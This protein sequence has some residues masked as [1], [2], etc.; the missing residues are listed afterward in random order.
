MFGK[1]FG[2]VSLSMAWVFGVS[3][4]SAIPFVVVSMISENLGYNFKTSL[5][6]GIAAGAVAVY[7]V[8]INPFLIRNQ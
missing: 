2:V 8:V 1:I 3:M 7:A 4:V 6:L 5:W